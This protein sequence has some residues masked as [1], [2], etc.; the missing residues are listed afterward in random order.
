[1]KIFVLLALFIVLV[2]GRTG[3]RKTDPVY[4]PHRKSGQSKKV[5]D[6]NSPYKRFNEV[7]P[8]EKM[9]SWVT[10]PLPHTYIKPQDLPNEHNWCN[11]NGRSFCTMN[12]NQHLPQYCGSCWAHGAVSALGDRVKIARN[13][14]KKTEINF[15]VQHVLNCINMGSC[16]GGSTDGVY[17]WMHFQQFLKGSSWGLSF[18]TSMPYMGCSSESKEGFCKHADTTCSDGVARTCSTF[19][20]NGGKCV[21]LKQYPNV[22][23]SQQGGVN[24]ADKMAAEIYARGPIACGIDATKILDYEGGVMDVQGDGIDHVISVTGWGEENGQQYW[25]V[26]NSWGEYWGEMGFIRVRK[27]NNALNLEEQC[28]WAVPARWTETNFP[29]YEDGSNC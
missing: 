26:R 23:I 17:S 2:L 21:N 10:T 13:T 11:L 25:W 27:G 1:M 4:N 18:E 15:S 19:S 14:T 6:P 20:E 24:G 22:T 16:H 7:V 8:K 28:T 29:C 3:S 12:R 5:Y 9:D